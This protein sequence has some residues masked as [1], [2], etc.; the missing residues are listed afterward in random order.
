MRWGCGGIHGQDSSRPRGGAW[1]GGGRPGTRRPADSG[2]G[3]AQ[4]DGP[5][6][7]ARRS[8][9]SAVAPRQLPAAVP[10]FAGRVAE[11]AALHAV[12]DA[13][14]P[15][16]APAVAV[17]AIDGPPGWA[18]PPWRCAGGT[19]SPAGSRTASYTSTCAGLTPRADQVRQPKAIRGMLDA[20]GLPAGQIPG[21]TGAQAGL[22]RSLLAGKRMLVLL[23]NVREA[24]QIRPL[25]PGG[26]GCLVVVTSRR[27]LDRL[28]TIE[29]ACPMRL[30]L[31][32]GRGTRPAGGTAWARQ[33]GRRAR[34]PPAADQA[35][36]RA[37]AGAG[38]HRRP[39]YSPARARPRHA[40]NRTQ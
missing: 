13:A 18:R 28:V 39:G 29:G 40:G 12:L 26:P 25:L 17:A 20:P 37:A 9:A 31:L 14:R 33:A 32:P 11:L 21:R 34:P 23:D 1:A 5:P 19:K 7:A 3:G 6:L 4:Q 2:G 35:V 16:R 10:H 30:G 8:Q 22:Y 15:G 36:R 24:D 27:Q 38:Y